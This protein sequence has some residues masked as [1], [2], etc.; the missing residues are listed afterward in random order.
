MV[1]LLTTPR[2]MKMSNKEHTLLVYF[3]CPE[4]VK[5]FVIPNDELDHNTA[6][7][8]HKA[9][10]TFVNAGYDTEAMTFVMEATI[11]DDPMFKKYKRDIANGPILEK[12]SCV[13]YAGF[14][15]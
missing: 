10:N 8:L 7:L 4:E 1:E 2:L 13:I 9:H 6:T 3:E 5:F 12:I 15:L 11:G 14:Y